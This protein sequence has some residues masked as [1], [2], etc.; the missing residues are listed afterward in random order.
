[1]SDNDTQ[2]KVVGQIAETAQA[3]SELEE[4][5]ERAAP[6][7]AAARKEQDATDAQISQELQ[8]DA[9]RQGNAIVYHFL[10]GMLDAPDEGARA[11]AG[12][13]LAYVARVI[14][15]NYL[16]TLKHFVSEL[17]PVCA[18]LVPPVGEAA[19]PY[20]EAAAVK[21]QTAYQTAVSAR[22]EPH[23]HLAVFR[24]LL[25]GYVNQPVEV[26]VPEDMAV[27]LS[28]LF[29]AHAARILDVLAAPPPAPPAPEA[30]AEEA[31]NTPT[32]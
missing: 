16:A 32:E 30:P 11:F 21:L 3:L 1:M 24:T 4:A 17:E 10:R 29:N 2:L 20:A 12:L 5:C 19:A 7:L 31:A 22:D 8:S 28:S 6:E 9:A 25:Q 15:D 18:A 23:A 14:S 26:Q 13:M 27:G